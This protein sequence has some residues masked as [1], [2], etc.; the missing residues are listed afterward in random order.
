MSVFILILA[1]GTAAAVYTAASRPA[2]LKRLAKRTG[3]IFCRSRSELLTSQNTDRLEIFSFFVCS[4]KNVITRKEVSAFTRLADM[5]AQDENGNK[6][7]AF[8]VFSAECFTGGRPVLKITPTESP[9]CRSRFTAV[10]TTDENINTAYR[11]FLSAPQAAHLLTA[12]LQRLLARRTD[13]YVEIYDNA[14]VYHEGRLV[15]P[16][17]AE[18]FRLRATRVLAELTKEERQTPPAR[19]QHAAKMPE[20]LPDEKVLALLAAARPVPQAPTAQNA[21]FSIWKAVILLLILLALPALAYYISQ[22]MPH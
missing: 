14:F 1:T 4:F 5:T 19:A 11:I 18:D 9:F 3:G 7:P 15:P 20:E 12:P 6:L 2:R 10:K 16:G 17:E 8:T 13:I 21:G 22:N